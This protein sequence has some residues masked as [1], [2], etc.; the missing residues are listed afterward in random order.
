MPS[1]V[2]LTPTWSLLPRELHKD[3]KPD[4]CV[5]GGIVFVIAGYPLMEH[6]M[7]N[8][9]YPLFGA[10]ARLI[11]PHD[12]DPTQQNELGDDAQALV[13]SDILAHAVNEG[14]GSFG[15]SVLQKV[16]GESV[17]NMAHLVEMLTPFLSE[18]EE[19][20][21]EHVVAESGRRPSAAAS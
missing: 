14:S 10:C 1:K 20:P 4:F 18:S 21:C 16:N 12:L 13:C 7:E 15:G 6:A 3:Y 5:V 8:D 9:D 17:R 2:I 19:P 11:S